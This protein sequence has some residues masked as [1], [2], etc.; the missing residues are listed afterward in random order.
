ML[1]YIARCSC[2]FSCSRARSRAR[3]LI[4]RSTSWPSSAEAEEVNSRCMEA[5][6]RGATL[7]CNR[8]TSRREW[9]D[10]TMLS[11]PSP[12]RLRSA[13]GPGADECIAKTLISYPSCWV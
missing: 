8:P 7:H 5:P 2:S 1:Q 10:S 4:V 6:L 9:C 11:T 13:A 12:S 3:L